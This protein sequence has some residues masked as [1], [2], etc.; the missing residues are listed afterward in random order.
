MPACVPCLI[1]KDIDVLIPIPLHQR[2]SLRIYIFLSVNQSIPCTPRLNIFL[3]SVS[4][5]ITSKTLQASIQGNHASRA[6]HARPSDPVSTDW[7]LAEMK[8]MLSRIC[9][10]AIS[11]Y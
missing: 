3:R 4:R 9:F 5:Q 10:S 8:V 2:T 11:K 7:S 1:T 6:M